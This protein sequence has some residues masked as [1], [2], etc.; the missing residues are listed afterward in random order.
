MNPEYTA[1]LIRHGLQDWSEGLPQFGSGV[2]QAYLNKL[3]GE[4]E[5]RCNP[6]CPFSVECTP[7]FES[8][9]A[10]IFRK[11]GIVL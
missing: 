4:K 9:N 8:L 7:Y 10:E 6:N 11:F 3:S 5:P 2:C 1:W